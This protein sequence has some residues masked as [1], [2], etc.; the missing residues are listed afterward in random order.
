MDSNK[1]NHDPVKIYDNINN[2]NFY[3]LF[4]SETPQYRFVKPTPTEYFEE[5]GCIVPSKKWPKLLDPD[6]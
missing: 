2:D 4:Q 6:H 1:S 3:S 5:M